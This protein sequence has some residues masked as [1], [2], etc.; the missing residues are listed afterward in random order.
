MRAGNLVE[1]LAPFSTR[2]ALLCERGIDAALGKD[3]RTDLRARIGHRVDFG[4][5]DD[6]GKTRREPT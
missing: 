1:H 5:V 4:I 6:I 2:D 3:F